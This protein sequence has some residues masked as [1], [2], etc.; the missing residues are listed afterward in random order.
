MKKLNILAVLLT[1]T[2]VMTVVGPTTAA[3]LDDPDIRAEAAMLVDIRSGKVLYEKNSDKQFSPGGLARVMMLLLAVEAI[4]A[5]QAGL[6][7]TVTVSQTFDQQLTGNAKT[8]GLRAG[9]TLILHDLLYAAYCA[10]ADDA[11]FVVAEYLAQSV[12]AFA[13]QMTDRAAQLGC[14]GTHFLD[15]GGLLDGQGTTARDQFII[16]QKAVSHQLFLAIAGTLTYDMQQAETSAQKSLQNTYVPLD[17]DDRYYDIR[18]TAGQTNEPDEATSVV[19]YAPGSELSLVSVVLGAP[20]E[21]SSED[22]LILRGY[23]ETAR[24]IEWGFDSYSWRTVLN[25]GETI[26]TLNVA[27]AQDAQQLDVVAAQGVRL[28]LP[29][30]TSEQ[31]VLRQITMYEQP[32]GGPYAPINRDDIFG[33][34]IIIVDGQY[35]DTVQLVAGHTVRLDQQAYI[36]EQIEETLELTWVRLLLAGLALVLICYIVYIIRYMYRRHSRRK[37]AAQARRKRL[38]EL[39]KVKIIKR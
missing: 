21:T 16:L 35:M 14:T 23:T 30:D 3:A 32:E 11:C 15:P 25:A 12:D 36:K 27:L 7:D 2:L 9:D 10:A 31:D 22:E 38:E 34:I 4:E 18:N 13:L 6:T 39:G 37:A 29:N 33:E 8:I 17:P 19:S 28:L 1:I 20:P 24:L 5:G 26:A